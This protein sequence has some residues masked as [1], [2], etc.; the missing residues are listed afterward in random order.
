MARSEDKKYHR[1][2][3]PAES[4]QNHRDAAKI[5]LAPRFPGYT[6][7]FVLTSSEDAQP[8]KWRH[9]FGFGLVA[10]VAREDPNNPIHENNPNDLLTQAAYYARV[11][12][13][14]SPFLL[15]SVCLLIFGSDFC[16]CFLDRDGIVLSKTFNMWKDTVIFVKVVHRLCCELSPVELG[17]DPTV[18]LLPRELKKPEEADTDMWLISPFGDDSRTWCTVGYPLW[19]SPSLLGRGTLVWRVVPFESDQLIYGAEMVLKTAW[20]KPG[21]TPEADIYKLL[22]PRVGLARYVAGGDVRAPLE[23]YRPITVEWL[24]QPS[25]LSSAD[26]SPVLHRLV[27]RDVG[28]ALWDFDDDLELLQAIR[29][30]LDGMSFSGWSYIYDGRTDCPP[31]Y[32]AQRTF[33]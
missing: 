14:S 16:V 20:R 4:S 3:R 7:D 33:R 9:L 28:R 5:D 13:S 29:A 10:A 21:R 8:K 19:S 27:T 22:G 15:S 1:R 24:R 26:T 18:R 30:I 32:S 6:P 2:F 31:S 23:G 17:Q 11:H 12:L 25:Q